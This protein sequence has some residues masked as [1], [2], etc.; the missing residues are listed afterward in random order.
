MVSFILHQTRS[1]T[2]PKNGLF[3]QQ[4]AI[5]RNSVT[6]TN[7]FW[8]IASSAFVWKR[9]GKEKGKENRKGLGKGK[10]QAPLRTSLPLLLVSA[11]H[12]SFFAVAGLFS[13]RVTTTSASGQALMTGDICGFPD[14][15]EN[16][17]GVEPQDL[18]EEGLLTFNTQV[19]LGRLTLSRSAAY[20]RSCYNNYDYRASGGCNVYVQPY[21]HGFNASSVYNTSCPFVNQ[22]TCATSSAVRYDSGAIH[23][24]KDLGINYPESDA[25]TIR[26]ITSCA[27]VSA[28]RYA[29]DWIEDLPE[30]FGDGR[31]T[32]RIKFYE[33]GLLASGDDDGCDATNKDSTTNL[34][35]FCVSEFMKTYVQEPYTIR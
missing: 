7:A 1:T 18:D 17:R 31:T 4:Q 30:A 5:L 19:V 27:P 14:V 2:A 28:E 9:K 15:V 26:R 24:N 10:A 3:H 23:S 34:T 16:L 12:I 33:M 8:T 32:T 13:S 35:T 29:T 6:A 20:V 21:L 22:E 11:I 25:M